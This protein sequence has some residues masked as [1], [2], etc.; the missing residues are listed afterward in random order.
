MATAVTLREAFGR[1]LAEQALAHPELVVLDADLA[2]CTYGYLFGGKY[3]IF[4]GWNGNNGP[5]CICLLLCDVY[6]G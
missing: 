1:R 3:D 5:Q 6:G 4:G 2:A